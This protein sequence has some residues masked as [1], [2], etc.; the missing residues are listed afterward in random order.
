MVF[1]LGAYRELACH[2][3]IVS[4]ELAGRIEHFAVANSYIIA[5]LTTEANS[6][7]SCEVLAEVDN[8]SLC[9]VGR[10]ARR[11]TV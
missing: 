8:V 11:C 9:R 2:T 1:L 5:A 3:E 6:N 7:P 4:V 10:P